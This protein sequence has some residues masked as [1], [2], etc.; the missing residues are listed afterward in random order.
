MSFMK[1][2][3][4]F[5]LLLTFR[6]SAQNTDSLLRIL[7]KMSADSQRVH[8]LVDLGKNLWIEGKDSLARRYLNQ[9]VTLGQKIGFGHF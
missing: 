8:V 1:K 6:L 7:P 9:A 5:F 4:V 3:F 2:R